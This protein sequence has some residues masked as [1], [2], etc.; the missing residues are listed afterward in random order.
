[1]SVNYSI[2]SSRFRNRNHE[3]GA[4]K[5]KRQRR[6]EQITLRVR[7]VLVIDLLLEN[8]KLVVHNIKLFTRMVME[9]TERTQTMYEYISI[10][11]IL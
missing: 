8:L 2:M 10:I 6:L 4:Q 7:R 3:S 11:C 5:R 9:I 1:M